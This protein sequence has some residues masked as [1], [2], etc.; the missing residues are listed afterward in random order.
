MVRGNEWQ[1]YLSD[2]SQYSGLEILVGEAMEKGAEKD[3]FRQGIG[4]LPVPGNCAK[5]TFFM[6]I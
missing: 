2:L 1:Y 5:M 6:K 3:S 4:D